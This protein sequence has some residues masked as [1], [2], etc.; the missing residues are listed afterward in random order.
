MSENI[1]G[2]I[3]ILI[4]CLLILSIL[5]IAGGYVGYRKVKEK[6]PHI[7]A[8]M[9]EISAE[10]IFVQIRLPEEEH[11][12]AMNAIHSFTRDIREGKVKLQ[13]GKRIAKALNDKALIGAIMIRSFESQYVHVSSL[14]DAEKGAA[15]QTLTRFAHGIIDDKIPRERL[16][17]ILNM[18]SEDQENR[19]GNRRLKNAISEEELKDVLLSMKDAADHAQIEN[20]AYEIDIA[21]IIREAIKKGMQENREAEYTPRDLSF[22]VSRA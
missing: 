12:A 3:K 2:W 5:I 8:R 18:I 13:Q 7:I 14:K 6:G 17:T 16:D 20:R 9:I 21:E 15:H 10:G 11:K 4:L 19:N 22:W 1:Q